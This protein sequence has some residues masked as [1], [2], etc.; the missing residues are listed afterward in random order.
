M[1]ELP[2]AIIWSILLVLSANIGWRYYFARRGYRLSRFDQWL[3][4]FRYQ[5]GNYDGERMFAAALLVVV[6]VAWVAG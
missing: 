4:H 6:L 2:A 5:A 1:T 3:Q